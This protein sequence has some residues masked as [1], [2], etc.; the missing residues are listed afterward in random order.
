MRGSLSACC[1]R[2]LDGPSYRLMRMLLIGGVSGWSVFKRVM[3]AWS[4]S[5]SGFGDVDDFVPV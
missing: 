2:K 4:W 5:G 1:G 3:R